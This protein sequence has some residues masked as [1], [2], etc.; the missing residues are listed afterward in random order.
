MHFRS[1]PQRVGVARIQE[2]ARRIVFETLA[3]FWAQRR[4]KFPAVVP[5]VSVPS[6]RATTSVAPARPTPWTAVSLTD[7]RTMVSCPVVAPVWSPFTVH[8]IVD[9]AG[10]VH[11]KAMSAVVLEL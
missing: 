4:V 3:V 8:A 10:R 6:G 1:I 7:P 5:V 2:L 11:P 9:P